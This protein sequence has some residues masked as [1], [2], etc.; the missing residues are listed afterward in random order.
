LGLE[1][2]YAYVRRDAVRRITLNNEID[3]GESFAMM[4]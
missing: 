2:A 1:E 4:A 3:H